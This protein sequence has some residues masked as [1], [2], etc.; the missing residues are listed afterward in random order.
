MRRLCL[1]ALVAVF[2]AVVAAPAAS[3]ETLRV[4]AA[5]SLTEAF[6]EVAAL[7]EKQHAGASVELNL[8]GSQVLRTQIEQGAPADVFASADLVHADA[9]KAA[10]VLGPYRVFARNTLAVVVPA[11]SPKVIRLQDVARPGIRVLVAGPAVPVGRYTTQVLAKLAAA[12]LYGDDFQGRVQA[13]VVSQETN[14]RAV[15]AKVALG[16]ADAGFVYVTDA[17]TAGPKVKTLEIPERYNVVA[18]YPVG[19]LTKS[20]ATTQAK[21]FVDL[22]LGPEGQAILIKHGFAQ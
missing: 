18:E 2:L 14:V 3:A 6:R 21:A 10:G 4:F 8:A 13:N 7:F 20:A 22:L 9:L 15:L 16:E 17:D 19:V 12:G 5:A 1:A 11:G